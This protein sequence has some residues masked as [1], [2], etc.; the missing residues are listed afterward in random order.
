[1]ACLR[2]VKAVSV[3]LMMLSVTPLIA[4][5]LPA[6]AK[7]AEAPSLELLEFLGAWENSDG[8]WQDPLELMKE[9][10]ELETDAQAVNLED[11]RDGQ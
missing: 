5:S 4:L 10:D 2:I 7:A 9:L 1:M 8:E 3:P 11:G 6:T